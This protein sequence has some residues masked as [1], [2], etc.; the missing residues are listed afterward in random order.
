MLIKLKDVNE[1][2]KDELS[3]LEDAEGI[4]VDAGPGSVY[5]TL[6]Y[7]IIFDPCD[8]TYSMRIQGRDV[9][10][11]FVTEDM[12]TTVELDVNDLSEVSVL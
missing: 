5:G 4:E 10:L 8:V 12:V 9:I 7:V 1:Y 11:E 2:K 6:L 3:I